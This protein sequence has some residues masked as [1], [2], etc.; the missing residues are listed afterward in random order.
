MAETQHPDEETHG[1]RLGIFFFVGIVLFGALGARLWYLQT[2]EHEQLRVEAETNVLEAVFEEAPRGRILDRNGKVLV[3]NKAVHVVTV[4]RNVLDELDVGAREELYLRLATA[5]SRSGRLTKVADIT[6]ALADRDYGPLERVPVAV[7][8]DPDLAVFT[9]ERPELFPGV[10]VSRQTIRVYPYGG[11]AA[12]LLGYVGPITRAEWEATHSDVDDAEPSTIYQLNHEI[13]KSGIERLFEA[14]LRGTPGVRYIEVKATGKP[15]RE[16]TERYRP[17]LPGQDV[18]LTIDIDLQA[19][20]EDELDR[21]LA[22]ARAR[23]PAS[24]GDPPF[25]ASAGSVVMLDPADGSLLAMASYPSYEPS[26]F[27]DGISVEQ[28]ET[29]TSEDNHSPIINRAIQ[30]SYAPGS[31]FKL[32]TAYAAL[33]EGVIGPE[34][35]RGIREGYRDT[36]DYTYS[37]CFDESDT[38][39]YSSPYDGPGRWVDLQAAITVSSDTYFYE[40]G[41]EGFWRRSSEDLD[42]DG[43]S[44]DEDLQKWARI[45]GLG[46]ETGIQLPYERSGAVPDREYYQRQF[47]LGV[48][49]TSQWF[50]GST[51]NLSIGQ[52]ELLVTPLQLVNTYAAFANGGRLHQPNAVWKVTEAGRPAEVVREIGPRVLRDLEIPAEYHEP[53]EQGLLFVPRSDGLHRGTA[54]QAF[55]D[56][57]F[58]LVAWPVAAK[59]GTAEVRDKADTSVFVAYGPVR[60]SAEPE[61]AVAAV[62]EEAGFGSRS[63][64]PVVARILE[65]IAR[66]SVAPAQLVDASPA[67]PGAAAG[68]A[69]AGAADAAGQGQEAGG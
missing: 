65:R 9:G 35:I 15:V 30:G 38:C 23:E 43:V 12:H 26:E 60:D 24:P 67:A 54:A 63:A 56:V 68:D 52:G 6:D 4:D 29:L 53:I 36:G 1:V 22:E 39:I 41:G 42:D 33:Q 11:L 19:L 31:T 7:D 48:F 32:V 51:I 69:E 25:V 66:D 57:G 2:I 37:R 61:V 44:E 27:A 55:A 28:F 18:W 21:G 49:G 17:P 50:G 8:V 47:D 13:G 64:A 59:T 14:D 5:V 3:D 20:A 46:S 58:P 45:M 40:I 16:W 34:G 10:Q 62:L